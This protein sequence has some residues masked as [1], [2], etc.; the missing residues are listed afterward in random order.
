MVAIKFRNPYVNRKDEELMICPEGLYT[1]QF[2][3]AGKK[4]QV[5]VG[6]ILPIGQMPEGT[7]VCNVERYP[8]DQ[9]KL[10]KAS[11]DYVTIIG[12]N[13][14]AGITKIRLPSGVKKNLDSDCRA[15]VSL[16]AGLR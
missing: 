6:N 13:E 12:H 15:M 7:I 4:A 16:N 10:G 14:D 1:G 11:G 3:Y 8:G 2:I 5:A 9:G